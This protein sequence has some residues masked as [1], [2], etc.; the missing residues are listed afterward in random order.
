MAHKALV[1]GTAYEITGGRTLV[2]GTGYSI[3]KGKTLVDG[4]AYEVGFSQ[5]VTV[6]IINTYNYY[7][8]KSC[9]VSIDGVK[10][11]ND[12]I[13]SVPIGTEIYCY[14]SYSAK[15]GESPAIIKLNNTIVAT[16]AAM[17]MTGS[18]EYYYTVTDNVR[19]ELNEEDYGG[20]KTY[21]EITEIPEGYAYVKLTGAGNGNTVYI[22]IDGVKYTSEGTIVVPI[23]TIIACKADVN[24]SDKYGYVSVNGS[25]V[26]TN[27]NGYN[28]TVNGNVFVYMYAVKGGGYITITEL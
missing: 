23:G 19:I 21:V 2:N 24:D 15:N 3:D 14:V 25:N 6:E 1:D 26:A 18:A 13:I 28:Y 10:Y 20:S 12:A 5:P 9:Y 16:A 7:D 27:G 8:V 17:G 11:T 4:T 22:T